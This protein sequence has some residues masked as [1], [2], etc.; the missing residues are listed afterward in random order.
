[1]N[2]RQY[3]HNCKA[4]GDLNF[5]KVKREEELYNAHFRH[6]NCKNNKKEVIGITVGKVSM[7]P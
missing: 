2:K 3:Y 5:Y 6:K 4:S 1:M 7:Q